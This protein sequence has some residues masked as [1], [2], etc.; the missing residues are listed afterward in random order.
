M[1]LQVSL[2]GLLVGEL[3]KVRNGG[4][5]FDY[6]GSWLNTPGARPVSL[7]LPLSTQRYTGDVVY[8]FFDNLLPDNPVI[9]NKIQAR[10]G[11]KTSHAFDLLNAIGS[12]CVGAIQLTATQPDDVKSLK[13]DP[14]TESQV[15]SL[16]R[17]YN[18][19]PLG[20]SLDDDFRISLAGAQKRP[21]YC[22][23]KISGASQSERH[24]PHIF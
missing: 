20:M 14:L 3:K 7:S 22:S 4:L 13:F 23:I 9:R 2:N 24:Q 19:L 12:D 21:R 17:G 8:N 15:A 10:F 18:D 11:V 5:H 16:L 6:D 1:Q